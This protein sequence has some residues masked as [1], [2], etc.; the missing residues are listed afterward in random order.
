MVIFSYY[1]VIGEERHKKTINEINYIS[2]I[3]LQLGL[4]DYRCR[5]LQCFFGVVWNC[6][7]KT[8]ML[9]LYY[10][11]AQNDNM[12]KMKK[13]WKTILSSPVFVILKKQKMKAFILL[14]K[15]K[16]Y[17]LYLLAIYLR[18]FSLTKFAY[19]FGN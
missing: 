3:D 5:K 2:K 10:L 19:K 11:N 17:Q 14:N 8:E 6:A 9:K 18:S 16:V 15:C 12:G 4:L 7:Y 13:E 1:D